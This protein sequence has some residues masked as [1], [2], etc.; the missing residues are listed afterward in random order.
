MKRRRVRRAAQRYYEGLEP[1]AWFR[2]YGFGP[3]SNG[4]DDTSRA[5]VRRKKYRDRFDDPID[6]Q[7]D[8]YGDLAAELA[9]GP[10]IDTIPEQLL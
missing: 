6:W 3:E 5:S 4:D 1:E 2:T 9:E 7:H 10:Q 8:L